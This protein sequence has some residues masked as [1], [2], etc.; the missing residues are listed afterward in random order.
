MRGRW[1][2][3]LLG[4][5]MSLWAQDKVYLEHAETLSFDENRLPDAQI[6][7]GDVQFRHDEAMMYCDSAYFYEASNSLHAFGHVRFNQGD[8]LLGFGDIL[9]YDGNT[10]RARMRRHVKLVHRH[11]TLTTDSL[12]YYRVDDLAYYFSGGVI[13]DSLNTLESLWGQYCPGTNEAVFKT[14]VHLDHPEFTLDADSLRYNTET[15]VANLI[16][17]TRIVYEEET[18]ILSDWGWYNTA[19]ET[20]MLLD[21]SQVIH[22]DGKQLTGDTI[23]Y[24]KQKGYGHI[25]GAMEMTDTVQKATL[26]G[27]YGEYYE[28]EKRGMATRRA[29]LED[30]SREDTLYIHADTLYTEESPYRL[31]Q[32]VQRDSVNKDTLWRDT[33]YRQVRAFHHVRTYSHEYQLVCDSMH[34]DGKDSVIHLCGMPVCWNYSQQVSADTIHVY[35]K[36]GEV[37]YAHGIGN[38]IMIKQEAREEFDQMMGKEMKAWV[39]DGELKEVLVSGNAETVFYPKEDDGTFIGL[40]R[41]QSSFVHVYLENQQVDHVL[42]TTATTGVL[43]PLN[44]VTQAQQYLVGYFWA[45]EERPRHKEDIFSNPNRTR[46]PEQQAVSASEPETEEETGE[47]KK[48]I[49]NKKKHHTL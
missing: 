9:Y 33:T 16:A 37:D 12:N 38:A 19:N 14:N 10:K 40:N 43:Y 31:A 5:V 13:R 4:S 7:R 20:S 24:D 35:L 42:F 45:V 23:Y 6:L 39:R 15:H 29:M 41:T 18:T 36:D 22:T 27:D 1:L 32:V 11:T 25:L 48:N 17:S 28:V 49:R 30:W 21:R 46:R 8:T 47:V 3:I 26:Y 2:V 44:Q 34:Y